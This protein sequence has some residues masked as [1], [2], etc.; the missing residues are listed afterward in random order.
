MKT[1]PCPC[2]PT[3]IDMFG[4]EH[5]D[6]RG[7]CMKLSNRKLVFLDQIVLCFHLLNSLH[8]PKCF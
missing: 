2:R 8:H 6:I 3:T 1:S 4:R 7:A 5:S